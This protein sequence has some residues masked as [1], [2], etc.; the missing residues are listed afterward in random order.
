MHV[1]QQPA[2]PHRVGIILAN[3]ELDLPAL[4]LFVLSMNGLQRHFEYEI[5]SP[6]DQDALI[7]RLLKPGTADR[8]LVR[9]LV[10]SFVK[11][12]HD[13]LEQEWVEYEITER[14]RPDQLIIV[15]L[16]TFSDD[17]YNMRQGS[18]SII[19]LGNWKRSMAPPSLLEFIR[20]LVVRES[21]AGICPALAKSVHLGT[22]SCV[23]DFTPL[24]DE[25][26]LK[27]LS[28]FICSSCR[29]AL[30]TVGGSDLADDLQ[31]VLGREW[32][33]TLEDAGS[34]ASILAKLRSNLFVSSGLKPTLWESILMFLE[35]DGIK[36][37]V[38]LIG[39]VALAGILALLGW[40]EVGG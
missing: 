23:C 8:E 28:G 14:S 19:G 22:R 5:L 26:R 20:T 27:V 9:S 35:T 17:Y 3:A 40:K 34:T 7:E 13:H 10:A 21:L 1:D 39:A 6:P 24:L 31:Y 32:V 15:S 29:Q 18:V 4:K 37:L 25:A 16:A 12:F 30:S 2:R 11:R 36:E 33:G 38:K